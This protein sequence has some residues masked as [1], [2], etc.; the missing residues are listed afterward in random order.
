MAAETQWLDNAS[1]RQHCTWAWETTGKT[2][3]NC[4]KRLKELLLNRSLFKARGVSEE[5]KQLKIHWTLYNK[6]QSLWLVEGEGKRGNLASSKDKNVIL[7]DV[8]L[9][10]GVHYISDIKNRIKAGITLS[11]ATKMGSLKDI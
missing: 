7:S 8:L 6:G 10:N 9:E 5:K 4:N 3:P 1:L 2:K 11:Q